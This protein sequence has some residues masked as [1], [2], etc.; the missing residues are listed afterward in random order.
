MERTKVSK[1]VFDL[2][3]VLLDW[4]PRYLYSKIFADER[5]LDWFLEHVCTADWILDLDRGKPFAQGVAERSALFPE[6]AEQISAFDGR[7]QETL[8][9]AIAG[10]VRLLEALHN[11]RWPI[12]ALTNFSAEK[13]QDTRPR[14]DFFSRFKGLVVSGEEGVVKPDPAIYQLMLRRFELRPEE[15]VFIDDKAANVAAAQALGVNA[16]QFEN[17]AQLETALR[18]YGFL[19]TVSQARSIS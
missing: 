9:G 1:I 16:I 13:Y 6:F 12:Y 4:S 18:D 5:E 11:E 17:P 7:W 14:Y 3:N 10:S 19:R 8:K 2:G 15:C